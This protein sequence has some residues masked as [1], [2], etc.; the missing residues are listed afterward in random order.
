MPLTP[1]KISNKLRKNADILRSEEKVQSLCQT[2]Y[3]DSGILKNK[4]AEILENPE[5]GSNL[6]VSLAK[7]P[8]KIGVFAGVKILGIRS[9]ARR[10]AEENFWPLYNALEKFVWIV[11]KTSEEITS[12][13]ARHKDLDQQKKTEVMDVEKLQHTKDA[14]KPVCSHDIQP[15]KTAN[16]KM[17][18]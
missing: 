3:G 10:K 2:V 5:R 7:N 12:D 18:I 14:K 6:L 9:D 16:K 15:R 8:E 4:M 1:N 13:Q 17:V 11:Q